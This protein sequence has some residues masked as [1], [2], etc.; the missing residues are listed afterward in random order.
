MAQFCEK[1]GTRLNPGALFCPE[2]GARIAPPAAPPAQN[3]APSRTM[4][5]QTR[6]QFSPAHGGK[7]KKKKSPAWTVL[8]ILF[9]VLLLGELAV[10]SFVAPGFLVR[11]KA[12]P[13]APGTAVTAS[14]SNA[15]DMLRY[16]RELEENGQTQAAAQI[17]AML[18]DEIVKEAE[19][20]GK[21]LVDE[22]YEK[23]KADTFELARDVLSDLYDL[24]ED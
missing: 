4:P 1:C 7:T 16:A 19:E 22:T 9:A 6:Q 2:C 23:R 5:Q 20:E 21:E 8:L 15:Q 11:P 12:E 18:P 13:A 17:Y 14:S 10:V 24:T 3:P